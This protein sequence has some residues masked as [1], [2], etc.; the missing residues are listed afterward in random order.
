M[1]EKKTSSASIRPGVYT[2]GELLKAA[3]VDFEK[4]A[5]ADY[6]AGGIDFRKVSVGGL[7]FDSL[8]NVVRVQAGSE[9]VDVRVEG[10]LEGSVAVD[11]EGDLRN[12]N[13]LPD[14]A[15]NPS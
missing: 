8:D 1:A 10:K 9:K 15:N 3:G 7:T 14:T 11:S 12:A 6:N 2:Y 13:E 4:A 5:A